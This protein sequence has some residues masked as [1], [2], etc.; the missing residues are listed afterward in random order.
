MST[1]QTIIYY[2]SYSEKG[3]T[4]LNGGHFEG[5]SLSDIISEFTTKYPERLIEG[6]KLHTA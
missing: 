4:F 2:I 3:K 6:V 1:K 5:N